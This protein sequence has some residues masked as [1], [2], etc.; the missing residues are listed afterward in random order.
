MIPERYINDIIDDALISLIFD[1]ED[2]VK[3]PQERAK[4][5]KLIWQK[6]KKAIK[7]VADWNTE[8]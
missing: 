4:L 8:F 2:I 7:E 6:E 5:I 3:D 1:V